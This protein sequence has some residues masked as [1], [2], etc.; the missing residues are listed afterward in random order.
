MCVCIDNQY[1]NDLPDFWEYQNHFHIDNDDDD[2]DDDN[3]SI[4]SD[5]S[6]PYSEITDNGGLDR[7]KFYDF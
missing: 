1:L 6:Q 2:D 4:Q 3:E 7:I 5:D